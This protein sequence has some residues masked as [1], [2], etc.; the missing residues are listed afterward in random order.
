MPNFNT[1]VSVGKYVVVTSG[2]SFKSL[3]YTIR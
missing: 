1:T 2:G 3:V